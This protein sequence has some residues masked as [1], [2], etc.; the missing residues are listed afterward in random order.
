MNSIKFFFIKIFT[1]VKYCDV[2]YVMYFDVNILREL[3]AAVHS[4][5]V[6]I[7][8]GSFLCCFYDLGLMFL[9]SAAFNNF[10]SVCF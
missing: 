9:L 2:M 10:F 1:W 4:Y 3:N 8:C 6:Q 7:L 5:L